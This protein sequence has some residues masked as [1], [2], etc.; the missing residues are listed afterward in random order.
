[1]FSLT[2]LVSIAL[3]PFTLAQSNDTALQV[4][5]IEAHFT[6]SQIVP[7]LLASF[8]PS[9]LLTANFPG[10]G[11]ITPGQA[12]TEGQSASQPTV[13][14][15]A[16]NS[17][18]NLDGNYTIMMVDADIV[19]SDLSKGENHHWLL[20]GVQITSGQVSNTSA[21]AIVSY[22]GPGPAAGSGPHR[23]VIILYSQP[24]SFQAPADLA[25]PTGVGLFV[26]DEY[27]KD[28]GLGPLV[29][30]TYF[31]VEDGTATVSVP[32]TSSVISST[33]AIASTTSGKVAAA[34]ATTSGAS[35]TKSNSAISLASLSPLGVLFAG[36]AVIIAA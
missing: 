35:P 24:D 34:T 20:N 3:L 33:L 22:A 12:L 7:Q 8:E 29:A 1:M 30:A 9:A 11:D 25:E 18:V 27:I 17:S 21:A 14:I 28:S 2:V 16:A 31:T 23:Y 5:A 15:A 19:G 13:T 6:Q 32:A 10:V 26:L 36:L 4:A